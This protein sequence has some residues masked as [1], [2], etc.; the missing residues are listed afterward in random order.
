MLDWAGA[1]CWF[2]PSWLPIRTRQHC[3]SPPAW[4]KTPNSS[5]HWLSLENEGG[6]QNPNALPPRAY[7]STPSI[8][9]ASALTGPAVR[10]GIPC[11][12]MYIQGSLWGQH[13]N[14][15]GHFAVVRKG[16]WR[17]MGE[18]VRRQGVSLAHLPGHSSRLFI[19][20]LTLKFS[21]DQRVT[22]VAKGQRSE[23]DS[24]A[25]PA[26]NVHLQPAPWPARNS[27]AGEALGYLLWL[28][29][30]Y[31]IVTHPS[32]AHWAQGTTLHP[33]SMRCLWDWTRGTGWLTWNRGSKMI[34]YAGVSSGWPGG[35]QGHLP[36]RT[37]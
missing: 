24:P 28:I 18:R 16:L 3:H 19:R 23:P 35:P 6:R 31:A 14:K 13:S 20:E 37:K 10:V 15:R 17:E 34:W 1:T 36:F 7:L 32:R 12:F 30:P 9:G 21:W 22:L 26:T 27:T 11:F 29:S 8:H 5:F 2:P 4:T 25:P 33:A